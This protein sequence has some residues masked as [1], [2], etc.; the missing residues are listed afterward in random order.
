MNFPLH[1][2]Q[3]QILQ[4]GSHSA[5][6]DAFVARSGTS[7]RLGNCTDTGIEPNDV[8]GLENDVVDAQRCALSRGRR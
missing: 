1:A 8:I 3:T 7:E 5:R 2:S 4:P 6:S